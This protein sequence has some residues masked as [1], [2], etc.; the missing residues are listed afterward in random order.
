MY[1]RHIT[2]DSL[3][4]NIK[5]EAE[6]Q[7]NNN[8]NFQTQPGSVYSVKTFFKNEDINIH[9]QTHKNDKNLSAAKLTKIDNE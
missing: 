7:W 9:F 4:I 2:Y 6:K 1:N 5:K 3:P 8:N